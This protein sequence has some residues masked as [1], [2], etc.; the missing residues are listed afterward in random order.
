M[1]NAESGK[2]E[3]DPVGVAYREVRVEGRRHQQAD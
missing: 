1:E 2:I 3:N